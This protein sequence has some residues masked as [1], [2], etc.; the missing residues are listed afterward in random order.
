MLAMRNGQPCLVHN[1]G[2]LKDTV[3]HGKTGFSFDGETTAEKTTDFLKQ[4]SYAVDL[5]FQNKKEW[6][7]IKQNAKKQRFTWDKSVD[8]YYEF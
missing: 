6:K 2:G 8:A 3:I 1:T 7:K 5:F 4:F